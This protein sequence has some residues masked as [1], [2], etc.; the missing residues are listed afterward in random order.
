[1]TEIMTDAH[2]SPAWL[3]RDDAVTVPVGSSCAIGR[4]PGNQVV[5]SDDKV[6]R[7]HALIHRQGEHEY[8]LVDLGSSNGS[9]L[10]GRRVSQPVALRD[11]AVIRIGSSTL[12]FRQSS[13]ASA[14]IAEPDWAD[15]TVHD[16]RVASCWLLVADIEGSTELSRALP[17][18]QLPII[19]G[20][21]FSTCKQAI[22]TNGGSINKY[23]GDGFFAYWVDVPGTVPRLVVALSELKRLQAAGPPAFRVVLHHGDVSIGGAATM[24][25]ESLAGLAVNFAFRMEKLAASLGHRRLLSEPAA[26]ALAG[27]LSTAA[28]G[29]HPLAG[30]DGEFGFSTF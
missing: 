24:G 16:I 29:T 12:V 27:R 5:L 13:P 18:N 8:W 15:G 2:D 11:R 28:A 17:S 23:L 20:K 21:W 4:A 26:A 19:V 14:E 10:D 25:E 3:V 9:Y 30:F 22:E 7:K 1:L 6:S